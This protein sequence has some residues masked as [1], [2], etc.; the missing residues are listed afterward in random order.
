MRPLALCLALVALTAAA[1]GGE[2]VPSPS[3]LL[4]LADDLG[5]GDVSFNGRT[6]WETPNLDDLA[7]RGA[8][9]THC[10]AGGAVCAPSRAVLLT[11]RYTVRNGLLRNGDDL[12][13]REVTIA[14][15]LRARGYATAL[16]GKWHGGEPRRGRAVHPMDQGFDEFVGFTNGT[17]AWQHFPRRLWFGRARRPVSGYA[18]TLFADAAIDFVRRHAGRPFFLCLWFTA[19][20]FHIQAPA[21]DVAR[22][23]GRFP[24][25]NPRDP[26]NA[27]YAAM[28]HRMD[29]ETGRVLQALWDAGM[30]E[31]T[32]VVFTSDHG[33]TFESGNRGA[34][35]FHDSN[36]PFRG[37]KRTL[38]EGGI[39]VPTAVCWPAV[40][41]AGRDIDDSAH[42]AD[43]LPTFLAAAGAAPDPAWRLD[44]RSVLD[45]WLGQAAPPQRT[46]FWEWRG[47]GADQAAA[48]RGNLKLLVD[49]GRPALYDLV[50]DPREQRNLIGERREAAMDLRRA[51][52]AWLA[53]GHR[54]E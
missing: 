8:R 5:W 28:I 31:R 18:D 9:L 10:Y 13:L 29:T 7:R 33:A 49:R 2:P 35:A 30:E 54:G 6:E 1:C 15:A 32:L 4:I 17:D 20:H 41:P 16:F 11:G 45:C 34:S 26:V 39:R 19:P 52:E 21:E 50:A 44:G 48:M 46:L 24:E 3:I 38:L 42:H 12:P 37:G 22:Y 36:R 14:E 23:R 27:A 43:F 51:L 40:L 47:D 25:R 53:A